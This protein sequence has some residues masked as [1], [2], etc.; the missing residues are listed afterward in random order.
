MGISKEL[1]KGVEEAASKEVGASN[2]DVRFCGARVRDSWLVVT[3]IRADCVVLSRSALRLLSTTLSGTTTFSRARLTYTLG[4]SF[5]DW[6]SIM[7]PIFVDEHELPVW[8]A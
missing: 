6:T 3:R 8:M 1:G 7:E 4:K 5:A 2:R